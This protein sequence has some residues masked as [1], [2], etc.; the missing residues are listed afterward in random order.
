MNIYPDEK[1]TGKNKD[2]DVT[3]V[4]AQYTG[5]HKPVKKKG[6]TGTNE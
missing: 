6:D 2:L 3:G 4:N 5:E 1:L